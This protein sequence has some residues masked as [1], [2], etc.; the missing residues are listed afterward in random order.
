MSIGGGVRLSG[1]GES[2][3]V[4]LIVLLEVF[5]LNGYRR[6]GFNCIVELLRLSLFSYIAN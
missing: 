4:S 6:T 2:L 5:S 1:A 3:N